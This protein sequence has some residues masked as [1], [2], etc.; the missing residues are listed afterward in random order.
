M[1]S[2]CAAV[3]AYALL[4]GAVE[5]PELLLDLTKPEVARAERATKV[6]CGGGGSLR[7][8]LPPEPPLRLEIISLD[9]ASYRLG[10]DLV[11]ELLVTNAGARNFLIP[12]SL[13]ETILR[14]KRCE[15]LAEHAVGVTMMLS[16]SF[17]DSDGY[18]EPVVAHMLYGVS[19][20]SGTLRALAPG[21]A[22]RVR[23]GTT[24]RLD[25]IRMHRAERRLGFELPQRFTVT[26]ML[27][28][29][30]SAGLGRYSPVRS[31]NQ[32]QATVLPGR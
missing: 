29:S 11:W 3:A 10:S 30:D 17:T 15:W 27:D 16:L 22:L 14:G 28:W 18:Y 26:A 8:I 2:T 13:D 31:E 5:R 19:S 6:G 25:S 21:Q 4:I 23:V 9:R 1:L 24:L 32:L 20:H 12:W 7:P